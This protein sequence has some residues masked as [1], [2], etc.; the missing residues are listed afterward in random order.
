MNIY[1]A[2]LGFNVKDEDLKK[3][4]ARYGEVSSISIVIDKITNRSRGFGFVEMNDDKAAEMAI[5]EL[6][7]ITL[8][9]RVIRVKENQ[10]K[11]R[12]S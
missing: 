10:A 1:V 11:R 6:N 8:D 12:I 4:F 2:N 9:N 5:R 7:G 3:Y